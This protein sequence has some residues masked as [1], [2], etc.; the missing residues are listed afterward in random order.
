MYPVDAPA[1]LSSPLWSLNPPGSS[2]KPTLSVVPATPPVVVSSQVSEP[3]TPVR[4]AR[5]VTAKEGRLTR[6]NELQAI[7]AEEQGWRQIKQ[8]AEAYDISKPEGGWDDA[9]PLILNIEYP[10]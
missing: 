6:Q 8:I 5:S 2:T 4:P 9:I 7:V 3:A 10:P 1:Y